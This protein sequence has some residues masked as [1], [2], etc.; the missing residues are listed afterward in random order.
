M[1]GAWRPEW[2]DEEETKK[3][4]EEVARWELESAPDVL[5]CIF[6]TR[7]VVPGSKVPSGARYKADPQQIIRVKD[8]D[9]E[10]LLGMTRD[11]SGCRGCGGGRSNEPQHYFEEVSI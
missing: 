4:L 6:H 1:T 11:V 3:W 10:T 8:E 2:S 9:R 5:R 7:L